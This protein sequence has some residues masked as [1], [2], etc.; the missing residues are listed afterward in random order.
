MTT[1]AAVGAASETAPDESAGPSGV[2]GARGPES[3]FHDPEDCNSL[4]NLETC[5][6]ENAGNHIQKKNRERHS[7][8]ERDRDGNREMVISRDVRV[9]ERERDEER[10]SEKERD[11]PDLRGSQIPQVSCFFG[12]RLV[13]PDMRITAAILWFVWC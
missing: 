4:P 8:G 2:N 10:G 5:K 12:F 1:S 9:G 11:C 6:Q 7:E 13:Q 3:G